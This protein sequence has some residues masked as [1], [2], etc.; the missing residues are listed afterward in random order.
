MWPFMDSLYGVIRLNLIHTLVAPDKWEE[1]N[2]CHWV[3][4]VNLEM[5]NLRKD[6]ISW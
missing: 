1:V 5:V 6:T 3:N 2:N 4:G